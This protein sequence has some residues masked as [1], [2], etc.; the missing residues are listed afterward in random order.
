M[1]TYDGIIEKINKWTKDGYQIYADYRDELSNDQICRI[2]ETK[3]PKDIF[4]DLINE[5]YESYISQTYDEL[6]EDFLNENS[7]SKNEEEIITEKEDELK[8]YFM[9]TLN[10]EYPYDHY[11]GQTINCDIIVNNK[12]KETEYCRHDCY[13]N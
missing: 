7:L 4:Y 12:D 9:D 8:Q 3:N 2:L 13:P 6:W 5:L 1:N 10:I 11:L